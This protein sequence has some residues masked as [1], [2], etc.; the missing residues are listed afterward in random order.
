MDELGLEED[1]SS[2]LMRDRIF[3]V[4][5]LSF[6]RGVLQLTT[7]RGTSFLGQDPI[8]ELEASDL[9]CHVDYRPRLRYSSYELSLGSIHVCDHLLEEEDSPFHVLVK[10]KETIVSL[11]E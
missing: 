1:G 5:S 3:A 6:E 10:P 7:S 4:V 8:L 11:S 2:K 9:H